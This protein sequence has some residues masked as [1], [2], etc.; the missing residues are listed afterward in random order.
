[1]T[2]RWLFFPAPAAAGFLQEVTWTMTGSSTA[3]ISSTGQ[4]IINENHP[5]LLSWQ[6][7]SPRRVNG[8]KAADSGATQSG[9]RY[10]FA[11]SALCRAWWDNYKVEM[12]KNGGGFVSIGDPVLGS[13]QPWYLN[14]TSSNIPGSGTAFVSGDII[15]FRVSN[16][17]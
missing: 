10:N 3:T 2:P 14:A 17:S 13:T 12:E 5:T 1:M 7:G 8:S 9:S 4:D 11:N 15:K 16:A 6:A